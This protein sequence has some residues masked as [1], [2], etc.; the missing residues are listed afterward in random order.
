MN[1]G[2]SLEVCP[3]QQKI[4]KNDFVFLALSHPHPLPSPSSSY[5]V[6]SNFC[7]SLRNGNID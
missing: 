3:K 1:N 7:V 5:I 2:G 4:K 6:A